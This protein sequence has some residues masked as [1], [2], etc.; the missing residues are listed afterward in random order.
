VS[1]DNRRAGALRDRLHFQRRATADDGF[2][3]Q[4]PGGGAFATQFTLR[5]ALVP[6]TGSEA[7]TAARL[8]GRQPYVV[9]VRHSPVLEDVTVAWRLVDAN[10]ANR[11]FNIASPPADPDGR[12]AWVEFLAVESG[13]PG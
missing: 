9:T 3:N 10:N 2:G 5:A 11:V 13:E 6:R 4:V 1:N 8:E 7:V 12:R